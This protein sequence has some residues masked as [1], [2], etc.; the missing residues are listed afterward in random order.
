[1]VAL[2]LVFGALGGLLGSF[3]NILSAMKRDLM[4]LGSFWGHLGNLQGVSGGAPLGLGAPLGCR[5]GSLGCILAC[6]SSKTA[7]IGEQ[8]GAKDGS[9]TEI[10]HLMK[11]SIK[12]MLFN[13]FS[14]VL[15]F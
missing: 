8:N 13:S 4:I 10:V 9:E 5:W 12:P 3:G 14:M 7:S 2:E 6:I 15:R 1:M 11:K